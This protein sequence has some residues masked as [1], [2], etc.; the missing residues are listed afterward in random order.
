MFGYS[1]FLFIGL[2]GRCVGF[3]NDA[4]LENGNIGHEQHLFKRHFQLITA[5]REF[6][7][8]KFEHGV[9]VVFRLNVVNRH[10][11]LVF[12]KHGA[13]LGSR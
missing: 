6:D 2:P 1:I 5:R 9:H 12:V 11:A 10:G 8:L 13:G 4:R 7:A 3:A